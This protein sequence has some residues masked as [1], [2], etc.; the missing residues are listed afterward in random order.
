MEKTIGIVI[1]NMATEDI[2]I[3]PQDGLVNAVG[4]G[5]GFLLYDFKQIFP[6]MEVWGIDISKYAVTQTNLQIKE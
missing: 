5:K 6:E 3:F 2:N 1:E 4:C